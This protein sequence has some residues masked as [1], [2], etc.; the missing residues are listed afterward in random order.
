MQ[1][2]RDINMTFNIIKLHE[3]PSKQQRI[4][5]DLP[6]HLTD[7]RFGVS[8]SFMEGLHLCIL[9]TGNVSSNIFLFFSEV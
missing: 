1:C 3:C 6:L 9:K 8:G 5:D 7:Y 4:N 2:A